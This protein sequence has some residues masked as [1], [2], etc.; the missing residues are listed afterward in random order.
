MCCLVLSRAFRRYP[1]CCHCAGVHK[2]THIGALCSHG[3]KNNQHNSTTQPRTQLRTMTKKSP[4]VTASERTW[5][6][7]PPDKRQK[8]S[9]VPVPAPQ[10]AA[11]TA[12]VPV[13]VPLVTVDNAVARAPVAKKSP[14]SFLPCPLWRPCPFCLANPSIRAVLSPRS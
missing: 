1:I 4:S 9:K 11:L 3:T 5:L 13:P 6:T 8:K 2:S 12:V 10:A 7:K 14:P